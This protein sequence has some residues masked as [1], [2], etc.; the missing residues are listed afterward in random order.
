M[1]ILIQQTNYKVIYMLLYKLKANNIVNKLLDQIHNSRL[2]IISQLFNT[3]EQL[4][5][6]IQKTVNQHD[7]HQLPEMKLTKHQVEYVQRMWTQKLYYQL[8]NY[9]SQCDQKLQHQLLHLDPFEFNEDSH[10]LIDLFTQIQRRLNKLNKKNQL[11]APRFVRLNHIMEQNQVKSQLA[12]YLNRM[13]C[14]QQMIKN[15]SKLVNNQQF[16]KLIELVFPSS[17]NLIFRRYQQI[18]K[19]FSLKHEDLLNILQLINEG[20]LNKELGTVCESTNKLTDELTH[21]SKYQYFEKSPESD[22]IPIYSSVDGTVDE[23]NYR[24]LSSYYHYVDPKSVYRPYQSYFSR[25]YDFKINSIV[26]KH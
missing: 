22:H 14:S 20:W 10:L 9:L 18:T 15:A 12:T 23:S 5:Q 4:K 19:R 17:Y 26:N 24:P 25:L 16:K 6:R 8:A 3:I 11:N 1:V 21:D 2:D 13:E 7:Q